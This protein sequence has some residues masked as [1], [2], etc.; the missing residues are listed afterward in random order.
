VYS[1]PWGIAPWDKGTGIQG[2]LDRFVTSGTLPPA[3][4]VFASEFGALY[5]SS[6]CTDSYD[7]RQWF[8]R[9]V[10]GTVVPYVD[11][12]YRTLP[13]ATGRSLLGYSEGAYCAASLL[14]RHPDVFGQAA[15]LSG[16]YHAGLRSAATPTAWR[17][18]GDDA[19]RIAAASP[20]LV[21]GTLSATARS[22][23]FIVLEAQ[24]AEPLF[25]AEYSGFAAALTG[26][27]I[28][29][30]TIPVLGVG[31]SWP[32]VRATLEQVLRLL[33]GRQVRMGVSF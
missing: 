6:E 17:V 24:P 21:V 27:G 18:F 5:P 14:V 13:W 9:Y 22:S 7:G 26:A 11:I 3:I 23:L 16:Y 8:E 30:A 28:A 2:L 33:V 15:A 10:V 12:H 4:F 19:A 1:A 25:G 32:T 29:H 31:H 20:A